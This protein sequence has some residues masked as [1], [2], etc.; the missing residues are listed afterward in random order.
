MQRVI[1]SFQIIL[2]AIIAFIPACPYARTVIEQLSVRSCQR[3]GVACPQKHTVLLLR[4]IR[5]LHRSAHRAV[6]PGGHT[7]V[8]VIH[9]SAVR[10][11][12]PR[13][14]IP[15]RSR[16]KMRRLSARMRR[17]RIV[18]GRMPGLIQRQRKVLRG[19]ALE[20]PERVGKH[21]DTHLRAVCKQTD[22]TR[23][24]RLRRRFIQR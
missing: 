5:H 19:K 21:L 22:F 10:L 11:S 13:P 23:V 3:S 7:A 4:F 20:N 6:R 16:L 17:M 8:R 2:G 9:E 12:V 14:F 15:F 24:K 18:P 1:V